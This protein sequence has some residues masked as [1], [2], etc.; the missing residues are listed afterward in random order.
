ME[1]LPT[2][3]LSCVCKKQGNDLP[4]M[5][6]LPSCLSYIRADYR[7]IERETLPPANHSRI[8]MNIHNYIFCLKRK[9]TQLFIIT[10]FFCLFVFV[11]YFA[12]GGARVTHVWRTTCPRLSSPFTCF[13]PHLLVGFRYNAFN[14]TLNSS[15]NKNQHL[16]KQKQNNMDPKFRSRPGK[17]WMRRKGFLWSLDV[18]RNYPWS[19]SKKKKKENNLE[20]LFERQN[21]ERFF[22]HR[23]TCTPH[24]SN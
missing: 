17:M 8:I 7:R 22:L 13:N 14:A 16:Q 10:W 5:S 3:R 1:Q 23:M 11:I 15:L 19:L 18:N 2:S 6:F 21:L 12:S 20:R 24:S 4:G 9:I